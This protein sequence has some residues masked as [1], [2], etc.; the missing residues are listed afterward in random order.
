MNISDKAKWLRKHGLF[1]LGN[2]GNRAYW[3]SHESG[4]AIGVDCIDH[5]DGVNNLYD[6]IKE[7]IF[8]DC[9]K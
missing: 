1:A 6:K 8:K 3:V 9:N 5:D 4:T 2:N 7:E